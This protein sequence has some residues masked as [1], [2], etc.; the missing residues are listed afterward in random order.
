VSYEEIN[1]IISK[2]VK[3]QEQITATDEEREIETLKDQAKKAYTKV[4]GIIAEGVNMDEE[5]AGNIYALLE[6]EGYFAN[7]QNQNIK[8]YL[9]A[10]GAMPF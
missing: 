6:A 7:N 1:D 5:E 4:C 9:V 3:E 8:D 2:A 10:N